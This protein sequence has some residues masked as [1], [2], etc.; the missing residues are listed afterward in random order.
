[1]GKF[2]PWLKSN[3]VSVIALVLAV[4]ALPVAWVIAGG[5]ASSDLDELEQSIRS[6]EGQLRG[7]DVTY[8][9]PSVDPSVES[10]SLS[11]PAHPTLTGKVKVQRELAKTQSELIRDATV[12][13]N[14]GEKGLLLDGLF[15]EPVAESGPMGRISLSTAFIRAWPEAHEALLA[16]VGAGM[17]PESDDVRRELLV[18]RDRLT[19][20]RRRQSARDQLTE[21]DFEWVRERL[22]ELRLGA[23]RGAAEGLVFYAEP[24]AFATM[25]AFN[26]EMDLPSLDTYLELFWGKQH[27]LWVEQDIVRGLARANAGRSVLNG[28]VKRVL[29]I[30]VEPLFPPANNNA[31]RGG[32][33]GAPTPSAAPVV[34]GGSLTTPITPD[35]SVSFTGR[36]GG[37]ALY[38]VRYATVDL[39]VDIGQLDWL[40]NGLAE[41][42]FM[43]VIDWDYQLLAPGTG[44]VDGF[45]YGDAQVA[46]LSMRVE[47]VWVR[48]W[49][50]D[51]VPGPLR[52]RLGLPPLVD[53]A[54]EAGAAGG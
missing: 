45:D 41:E 12:D 32:R 15:P 46:R 14:R 17:P 10:F 33:G 43:T 49:Y 7:V 22:R 20:D 28:A 31:G 4:I 27:T 48:S 35:Y 13:R 50:A 42:N 16:E 30:T 52:A 44:L 2:V 24:E 5:M 53:P 21:E 39:I 8:E 25:R 9:I 37:N 19:Q 40:L 36:K 26:E 1:M 34:A 54:A 3:L 29:D 6:V 18:Q 47:T 51:W 38:D 11:T 23:Y